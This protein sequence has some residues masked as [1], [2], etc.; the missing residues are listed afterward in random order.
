[1]VQVET[2]VDSAWLQQLKLKSDELLSS[3]GIDSVLCP[4]STDVVCNPPAGKQSNTGERRPAG[5]RTDEKR[6][7]FDKV[8][9]PGSSQAGRSLRTSALLIQNLPLLFASICAF[10]LKVSRAPISLGVLVVS[11]RICPEQ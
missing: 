4:C 2:R 3:C 8:F 1:V 7:S 5:K 10:T 6:Y 9:G 11:M